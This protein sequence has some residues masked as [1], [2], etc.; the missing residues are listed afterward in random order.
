MSDTGKLQGIE[1]FFIPPEAIGNVVLTL[2]LTELC[3][4]AQA[5]QLLTAY[6]S[7]L[8]TE[9][10]RIAAAILCSWIAGICGAKYALLTA[11]DPLAQALRLNNMS[12]QLVRTEGYPEFA[13][14]IHNQWE[15]SSEQNRLGEDISEELGRFYRNEVRPI[16]AALARA[17][18]TKPI[19]L[20]K[21]VYNQ[22]YAFIEEDALDVSSECSRSQIY[23][24]FQASLWEI[25]PGVF[26]LRSNPFRITP[27]FRRD[28]HPPYE[29]ISVKAT[30]CLAYKLRADHAYCGGCPII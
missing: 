11:G 4:P 10:K 20:W 25:P 7:M 27:K 18:L 9:D 19:M 14:P 3:M 22:L 24:H 8:G 28:P 16:I 2:P 17:S 5:E 29:I 15:S 12:V 23:A 13:F 30:C 6:A 1:R 21:Q 26:G